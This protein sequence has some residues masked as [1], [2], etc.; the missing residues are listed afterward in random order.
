MFIRPSVQIIAADAH[1]FGSRKGAFITG[2]VLHATQGWKNGVT[3]RFQDPDA[4]ASCHYLV[5]KDGT[6]IQYVTEDFA[7]WH[8]GNGEVN[9]HTVGIEI[10]ALVQDLKTKEWLNP[11]DGFTNQ[12]YTSLLQLCRYLVSRY[13]IK[14][15]RVLRGEKLAPNGILAHSDVPDPHHEGQWGGLNHHEDPGPNFPWWDRLI[16]DLSPK[17]AAAV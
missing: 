13:G 10:E 17:P 12:Q 15:R 11:A 14:P 9:Q 4:Q 6:I 16:A 5:C 1:N 7:A 2:I 3:K 8:S